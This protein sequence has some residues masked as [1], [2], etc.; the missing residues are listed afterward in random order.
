GVLWTPEVRSSKTSEEW[1]RRMQSVCFSPLAMLNAWSDGTK[2]WSFPDVAA[3]V[4]EVMRLRLRLLPY[5]YTSFP[6]YHFEGTPPIRA[7]ARV[8]GF[9]GERDVRDQFMVGDNLLVAPLFARDS[10]RE[11]TLPAGTWYDFYSGAPAGGGA[12]ITITPGLE[13]IPL[14]VRDGGIIPLLSEDRRQVPASDDPVD[15]EVRHYGEAHGRFDPYAD[16]RATL[17]DERRGTSAP[18]SAGPRAG[19]APARGHAPRPRRRTACPRG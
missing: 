4:R 17:A 6:Q 18:T 3:P 13:R 16:D 19:W 14:F 2:P 8:E 12:T 5:L 1:L 11:V 7:M 15:L 9:S 10:S